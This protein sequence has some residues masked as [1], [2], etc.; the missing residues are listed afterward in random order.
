VT[1]RVL[2]AKTTAISCAAIISFSISAARAVDVKILCA[3]GMREVVSELQPRIEKATGLRITVNFGE[4]GDLRKRIQSGEALDVVVLP[5]VVLDQ[6]LSDGKILDGTIINLA[7]SSMGIGVRADAPKPDIGSAEGLKGALL[8]AK[9]IA[10]TDPAS[11]GVAGVYIAD[12]FQRLGIAEQLKPKLIL[13]RGQ[14]NAQFVA[15][16]EADIAIQLSNEIRIVPG[17]EFIP[18]PAIFERTF[19]FSAAM[20]SDTKEVDASRAVLQFLSGPEAITV[21]R[22]KGMDQAASN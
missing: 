19:V 21:I 14:R 22:A 6:V 3:S 11:G 2:I 17:I 18:L 9:S 13:T 4:A 12:V 8:A 1:G 7:Q 5:R 16:G 15:K 20:A 10:V